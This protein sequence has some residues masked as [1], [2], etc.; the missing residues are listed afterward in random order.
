MPIYWSMMCVTAL[1][2]FLSLS[3]N[4]LRYKQNVENMNKTRFSYAFLTFAYIAFF[5]SLRD[6]VKDTSAYIS[7]FNATPDDWSLITEYLSNFNTGKL[8]YLL[9]FFFKN[10]IS[11]NHYFWL[12]FLCVISLGCLLRVYY[13]RSENFPFTAFL[14]M[15]S[16]SFIWLI[17]GTRQFLVVCI[18]FAFSDWLLE[19]KKIKYAFLA[20]AL[21]F[22]HNAAIFMI[23][24]CIFISAKKLWDKRLFLFVVLTIIGTAFSEN[25]FDVLND[26]L[27]KDYSAGLAADT[28]SNI[29]RL[30]IALVPVI[31]IAV[32]R[33]IVEDEAD[34]G[35]ILAANMSV[36]NACFYLA[37]TFTSGILVGRMPI[38]FS[39]YNL[40]LLPWLIK[41]CFKWD[42]YKIITILCIVFYTLYFYYQMHIAWDGLE[43]VSE[44]L[45]IHYY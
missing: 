1:F 14:F 3:D 26:A 30:V 5:C 13:K 2:A 10:L 29:L 24:V 16:A 42:K 20:Y 17:N 7:S 40:Y 33:K 25:V 27:D 15:A 37:S 22:I 6:F 18:L 21:S 23:P 32:E 11:D 41:H 35:I 31:I 43:Y 34:D 12:A 8:F 9:Q 44:I 19:G 45:N 38:F 4:K 36:V 39:V 28:G